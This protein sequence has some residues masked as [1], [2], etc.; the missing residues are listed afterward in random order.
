[1][2]DS[3]QLLEIFWRQA[4]WVVPAALLISGLKLAAAPKLKG[5]V[6][7]LAIR[8]RLKGLATDELHDCILPDGRGGMTQVDHLYLTGKGVHVIETKNYGGRI[9]G[10]AKQKTWTQRVGRRSIQVQNPLRQ[11]WG[12]VQAVKALVGDRAPVHGHVVVGG[13]AQFPK[14]E[15]AGVQ[16]PR[17]LAAE[18]RAGEGESPLPTEWTLAWKE[19]RAAVRLDPSARKAHRAALTRK[20][21]LDK[22]TLGGTVMVAAGVLMSVFYL[23]STQN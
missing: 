9:F 10:T 22:A 5:L 15:P 16:R 19:V 21:G 6:G 4:G 20:H 2:I 3:S 17:E 13:R 8:A 1:M 18:F 23:L 11:N 7:E 12:H 14:G